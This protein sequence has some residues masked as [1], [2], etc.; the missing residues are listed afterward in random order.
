[1]PPLLDDANYAIG[2]STT[3]WS[4]EVHAMTA[5]KTNRAQFKRRLS[6][7]DDQASMSTDTCQAAE[8]VVRFLFDGDTDFI[9]APF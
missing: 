8:D 3:P 1:M 5:S 9:D 7:I 6:N 2:R 4:A